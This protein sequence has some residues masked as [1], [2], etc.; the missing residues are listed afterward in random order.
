M[1]IN[2]WMGLMMSAA[3]ET[4]LKI[5]MSTGNSTGLM[6]AYRRFKRN[7]LHNQLWMMHEL[8]PGSK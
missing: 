7:V 5:V 2:I 6:K 4:L 1:T 3:E 8:K